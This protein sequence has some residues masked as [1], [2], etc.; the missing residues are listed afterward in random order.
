M[1]FSDIIITKAGGIT[2]S[3]ALSKGMGIILV[4]PIPGQEERNVSYLEER[5]VVL[6]ARNIEEIPMLT[7]SLLSDEDRLDVL[8][9]RARATSI[10]D[11]SLRLV[12]FI[13]D[14]AV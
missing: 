9:K 8:R 14:S 12:H 7:E 1:D 13:A 3:E 4:D 11:S 10:K 5:E 6:Y 2:V